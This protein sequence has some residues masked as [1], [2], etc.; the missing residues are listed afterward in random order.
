MATLTAN[1]LLKS[2]ARCGLIEPAELTDA[3]KAFRDINDGRQPADVR[4]FGS[5][6][7]QRQL[8]TPWQLQKILA[9]KTDG[10]HLGKYRLLSHIGRG[11]MGSV[12]LALH[13]GMGRRVALKL[14]PSE[15]V[16][17]KSYLERFQREARAAASLDH[18]HIVRAHDFDQAGNVHYLVMEFVDGPSLA[19]LVKQSAPLPLAD[20][21]RWMIQAAD[22]LQHA[23][24]RSIVHRDVKPSNLLVTP[25]G[26][27]KL[28]D[29]GL[30]RLAGSDASSLT[31]A[32]Q[33]RVL[34]TVDYLAPEQAMDSHT[35]DARADIYSLGCTLYFALTGRPPFHEGTIAQR[36]AQHQYAA[37]PR[38]RPLRP[39]APP[40]LD[41]VCQRML[42]KDPADRYPTARDVAEALSACLPP[43]VPSAA[44]VPATVP[45]ERVNQDDA[46]L[47]Y[48]VA[49]E[50]SAS[51]VRSRIRR[52]VRVKRPPIILWVAL[53]LLVLVAIALAW[54]VRQR[55]I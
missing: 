32:N 19:N 3:L 33:E 28:L 17:D 10:F 36:I 7:V 26:D 2:I 12:Y 18:P 13:T 35:A 21:V 34:G 29:L 6:L 5:F 9:G 31:V 11:G 38:L 25:A 49:N 24:D 44:K 20:V 47:P 48:V 54:L 37:P 27:I 40:A 42:G 46:V 41:D 4:E 53:F 23:H 22:A 51:S 30:A 52:P 1:Q 14:L 15:L 16:N 55:G 50:C 8:L 43:R 45:E 39:D